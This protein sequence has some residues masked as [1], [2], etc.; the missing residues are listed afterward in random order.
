MCITGSSVSQMGR[1]EQEEDPM[2]ARGT[3]KKTPYELERDKRVAELAKR[4]L[5]VSEAA[6]QL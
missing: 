1:Q 2:E 6:D 3:I 5:L 4:F